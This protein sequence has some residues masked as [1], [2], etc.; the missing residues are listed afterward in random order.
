MFPLIYKVKQDNLEDLE[1]RR[2]AFR[3]DDTA[4]NVLVEAVN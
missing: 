2:G 4:A 1:A 3:Y